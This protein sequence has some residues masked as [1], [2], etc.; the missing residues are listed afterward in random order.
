MQKIVGWF[1]WDNF[2][3]IVVAPAAAG[4]YHAIDGQHRLEAAKRHPKVSVVPA[5]II[6]ATGTAAEA[7]TFVD[8]NGAH[9]NVSLLEMYWA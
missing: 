5:I 2:S 7:E 3:A 1:A 9:K 4:R 6:T 8:V